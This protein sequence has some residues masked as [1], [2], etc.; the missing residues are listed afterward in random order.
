MK[1]KRKSVKTI[2][3][4][5][6]ALMLFSSLF[7]FV[8]CTDYGYIFYFSV[9]HAE[10]QSRKQSEH[11]GHIKR[12]GKY[13]GAFS[14]VFADCNNSRKPYYCVCYYRETTV[15]SGI[16]SRKLRSC[17]LIS[18]A[19]CHLFASFSGDIFYFTHGGI[20][21]PFPCCYYQFFSDLKEKIH[22]RNK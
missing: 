22:F 13:S 15:K 7:A 4:I 11:S 12:I 10:N 19:F 14:L 21:F 3:I 8:G 17:V 6:I 18:C 2:L 5:T 1:E 16:L 20:A 9:N